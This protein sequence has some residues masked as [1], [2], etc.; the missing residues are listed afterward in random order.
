MVIGIHEV[1]HVAQLARLELT[2]EEKR[3]F[4]EQLG[5]ILEYAAKLNELDTSGVEPTTHVLP[6]SNVLREDEIRPSWPL[7]QVL[8]N[9][10]D[11]EDGQFK[12]PAVLE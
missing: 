3:L 8:R 2:E 12:V 9:A 1:E 6:I 11:E 5:S 7:E 10:P 4:A